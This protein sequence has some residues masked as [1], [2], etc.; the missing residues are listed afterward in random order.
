MFLWVWYGWTSALSRVSPAKSRSSTGGGRRDGSLDNKRTAGKTSPRESDRR[1]VSRSDVRDTREAW[2]KHDPRYN[3][4]GLWVTSN[5]YWHVVYIWRDKNRCAPISADTL[6]AV[7]VICS[8]PRSKK[9][10]WKIK[11]TVHNFQN[12]RQARTDCNMVK[13]S[14]SNAPSTWLIFCPCTHTETSESLTFLQTRERES[15]L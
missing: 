7:S 1:D 6:S 15:T 5:V 13:S 10:S 11:E 2:T 3:G 14:S 4:L 8:L 12:A 9:K